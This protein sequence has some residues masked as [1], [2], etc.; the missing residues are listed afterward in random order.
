MLPS[1]ALSAPRLRVW[2]TNGGTGLLNAMDAGQSAV[3]LAHAKKKGLTTTFDLIAPNES[4]QTLLRDLLP[5]VDYFMPSFE[6]AQF[7]SGRESPQDATALGQ[8][9]V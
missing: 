2:V 8:M 4:T 1:W 6:E 5:H 3:L 9:R 7:I